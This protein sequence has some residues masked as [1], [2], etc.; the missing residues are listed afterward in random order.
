M[1]KDL[2]IQDLAE[3]TGYTAGHLCQMCRDG[4]IPGAYRLGRKWL[5]V[6]EAW[7]AF[8]SGGSSVTGETGR[9]H[10]ETGGRNE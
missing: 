4:K 1:D 6:K 3:L 9:E 2:T 5:V 10:I 7:E 8:R